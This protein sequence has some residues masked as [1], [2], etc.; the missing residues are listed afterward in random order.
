MLLVTEMVVFE[1]C[2]EK[3]TWQMPALILRVLFRVRDGG[4]EEW[5][6]RRR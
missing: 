4:N 1:F 2:M 6:S 3:S 5:F